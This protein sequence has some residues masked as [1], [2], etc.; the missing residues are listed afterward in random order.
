MIMRPAY[1]YT[2]FAWET[3]DLVKADKFSND[4][5]IVEFAK[6]Y[7]HV[8]GKGYTREIISWSQG[9]PA[10]T[11]RLEPTNATACILQLTM[12]RADKGLIDLIKRKDVEY[13]EAAA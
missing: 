13:H 4:K 5:S 3:L 9:H 7:F 2:F 11:P 12:C 8:F 1:R 6:S 10:I